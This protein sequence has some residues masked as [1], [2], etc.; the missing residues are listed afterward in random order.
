MKHI[1]LFEEFTLI[2]GL[3]IKKKEIP[4]EGS[5]KHREKAAGESAAFISAYPPGIIFK[6]AEQYLALADY[7]ENLKFHGGKPDDQEMLERIDELPHA[8]CWYRAPEKKYSWNPVDNY[9]LKRYLS[10]GTVTE[11]SDYFTENPNF[12]GYQAGKNYGI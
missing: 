6:G 2:K 12:H 11:F 4:L 3:Y 7:F 9:A 8:I 1:K 5:D 10:A